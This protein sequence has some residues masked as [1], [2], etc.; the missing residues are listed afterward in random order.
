M[1]ILGFR[2]D[3]AAGRWL[4]EPRKDEASPAAWRQRDSLYL[5]LR[6]EREQQIAEAEKKSL[7]TELGMMARLLVLV[8]L[9]CQSRSHCRKGRAEETRQLGA[10]ARAG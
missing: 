4:L 2:L 7:G 1:R 8:L 3:D 6:L 10:S 9:S 5:K